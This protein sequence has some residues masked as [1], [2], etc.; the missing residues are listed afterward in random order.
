MAA[1]VSEQ[2][3]ALLACCRPD[4]KPQGDRRMRQALAHMASDPALK[5]A[6]TRQAEFD[7]R[8]AA[9]VRGLPLPETFVTEIDAALH[10]AAPGGKGASKWR[11]LL[12]QPVFWAVLLAGAVLLGYAGNAVYDHVTGFTGDDTVRLLI[13]T[14]RT[15][16]HADHLEPLATEA[17]QLGDKLFIQY[18]LEDYEV[19]AVFGHAQ[20]ESYRVFAKNDSLVAEVVAQDHEQPLVFLMFRADQQGVNI[21][22]PGHWKFLRGDAWSAAVMVRHHVGFAAITPGDGA[23]LRASLEKS[24]AGSWK[25][26]G[27]RA[28]VPRPMEKGTGPASPAPSST[29]PGPPA[30][31][32]P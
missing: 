10:E 1:A 9:L 5:D 17:S 30:G 26:E 7:D 19:P 31:H 15:G 13:E 23:A 14:A 18:G 2:D 8:M 22:L 27:H 28:S 25:P 16:P 12:R 21:H 20:T 11:G 29:P 32:S 4:A 24:E 6:F 3:R